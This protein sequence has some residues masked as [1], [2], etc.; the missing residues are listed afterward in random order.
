MQT[1]T[2]PI[3]ETIL[4]AVNM[5]KNEIAQGMCS[6]FAVKL[7]RDGKL[8]LEQ[9][10]DFCKMNIYDF[11]SILSKAGVS[12]INYDPDELEQEVAGFQCHDSSL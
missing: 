10:A 6:E 3:S 8:S 2:I 7:F 4:A 11:L 1:V 12:V 5:D 9:S